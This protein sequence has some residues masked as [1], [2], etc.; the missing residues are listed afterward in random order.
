MTCSR[1]PKPFASLPSLAMKKGE[2]LRAYLDHYCELYNQIEGD[3]KGIATSTFKVELPIDSNLRASLALKPVM[4]MNKLMEWVEYKRLE[5]DQLQ[6][7]AKTKAPIIEKKKVKV[8]Q[9]PQPQNQSV[10]SEIYDV[11]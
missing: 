9:A 4:D 3:N 1:T 6:D 5:D 2:T 10:Q 7:K 11:Q 8:D